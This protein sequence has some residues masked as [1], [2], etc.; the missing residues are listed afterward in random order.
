MHIHTAI[1][2]PQTK[3]TVFLSIPLIEINTRCVH[4]LFALICFAGR[5][6]LHETMQQQQPQS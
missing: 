5:I 4:V 2:L 3:R 6:S 1:G